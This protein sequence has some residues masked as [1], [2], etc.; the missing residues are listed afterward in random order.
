M[1]QDPC[2]LGFPETLDRGSCRLPGELLRDIYGNYVVAASVLD[3]K[4][5]VLRSKSI[6][7]YV[8]ICTHTLIYI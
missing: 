8:Y 2:P 7:T 5:K 6:N 4:L 1:G 3:H